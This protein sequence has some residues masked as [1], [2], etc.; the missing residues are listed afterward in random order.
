MKRL[1]ANFHG[2][3]MSIALA[4][5]LASI[6]SIPMLAHGGF[7]HVAGNVIKVA[8]G[9]MT[10]QTSTG[11]VDVKLDAK[12][13]ISKDKQKAQLSDLT[14]GTRVVVDIPESEAEGNKI[15]LAQAVKIGNASPAA[16]AATSGGH[17]GHDAHDGHK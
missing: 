1:F 11:P 13:E 3:V 15:K 6:A 17:E 5:S 4:L 8:N 14:P 2:G 7:E 12:T 9:V 16:G 10:L